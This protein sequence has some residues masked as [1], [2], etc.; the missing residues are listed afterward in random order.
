MRRKGLWLLLSTIMV[1]IL[2]VVIWRFGFYE[3]AVEVDT[4]KV[5]RGEISEVI[6][7]SGKVEPNRMLI[8]TSSVNGNISEILVREGD[9]VSEGQSV[10]SL[11]DSVLV[12]SPV[13]G[14]VVKVDCLAG[15][16][17]AIGIPL[18]IIA[19]MDPLYIGANVD[20]ADI[21]R[22]K[23]G[24]SV[25]IMLDAYPDK[26]IQG[27][28]VAISLVAS[29]IPI[30]GTVFPV[31]I[32]S[33]SV[34]D[35]TLRLGMSADVEIVLA[36][37]EDVIIIPLEAVIYRE[38]KHLVFVVEDSLAKAQ[39]VKVGIWTEDTC[40]IE[41]GLIEGQEIMIKNADKLKGGEKVKL[42]KGRSS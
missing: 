6:Y 37:Y 28:I 39:E 16:W 13:T 7:A 40:Q 27:K 29:A 32:E 8:I 1:A 38:G 34:E 2:A 4:M 10:V 33:T 3:S 9:E 25:R 15:Q 18:M 31:R 5:K 36:T 26:A 23:I 24:Q 42:I 17:I 12:R 20:E 22:V 35:A 30:G 11:E 41:G 19:E 21:P 14:A